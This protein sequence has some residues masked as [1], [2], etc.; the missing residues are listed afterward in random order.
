LWC[1]DYNKYLL[2]YTIVQRKELHSL[3]DDDVNGSFLYRFWM[4]DQSFTKVNIYI[5]ST[6]VCATQHNYQHAKKIKRKGWRG[7][8]YRTKKL[9]H[10]FISA[11]YICPILYTHHHHAACTNNYIYKHVYIIFRYVA[12]NRLCTYIQYKPLSCV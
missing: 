8:K 12:A 5:Y 7:N 2:V 6:A 9:L 1:L 11:L 4:M 10:G 3:T